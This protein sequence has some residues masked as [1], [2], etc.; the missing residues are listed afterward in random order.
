[1]KNIVLLILLINSLLLSGCKKSEHNEKMISLS[2]ATANRNIE[3]IFNVDVLGNQIDFI[4]KYFAGVPINSTKYGLFL[5]NQYVLNGCEITIWIDSNK[6]IHAV[7][8]DKLSDR[9]TFDSSKINAFGP[10]HELT[11]GSLVDNASSFEPLYY[12]CYLD[13]LCGNAIDPSYGLHV[14]YP[15]SLQNIEFEIETNNND[16]ANSAAFDFIESI[17]VKYP[18][19]PK[20]NGTPDVL[21]G[22]RNIAPITENQ[23]AKLWLKSFK[24][25]RISSIR[26]GFQLKYTD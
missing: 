15:R 10:A 11:F 24:D 9:C 20:T 17:N 2:A 14:E 8:M 19:L 25:V 7:R 22:G 3:K 13:P 12:T 1:M 4:E 18:Y 16:A 5:T 26:F 21:I 6:S 23:Y